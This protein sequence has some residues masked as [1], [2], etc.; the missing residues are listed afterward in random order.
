SLLLLEYIFLLA[1]LLIASVFNF[2]SCAGNVPTD[3]TI[4][5]ELNSSN[6]EDFNNEEIMSQYIG[7]EIYIHADETVDD[8]IINEVLDGAYGNISK[9]ND[10]LDIWESIYATLD[11]S[12]S[13][14][15]SCYLYG[16]VRKVILPDECYYIEVTNASILEEI[17]VSKDN[18]Y[19]SS[20]DGILYDKGLTGLKVYPRA[21]KLEKLVL[22][23]TVTHFDHDLHQQQPP[24]TKEVVIPESFEGFLEWSFYRFAALE[25]VVFKGTEPPAM[26]YNDRGAAF[27]ECSDDIKFYVP[28]GCKQ[29]YVDAWTDWYSHTK[30]AGDLADRIVESD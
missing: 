5:L 22:P 26:N 14:A 30:Y 28:K 3:K 20:V 17:L 13:S 29:A 24:V 12:D 7:K 2:V 19:F 23:S 8:T 27:K 9:K 21:N 4:R 15:L 1:G 18:K 25:K 10:E 16:N 6:Y 11:L